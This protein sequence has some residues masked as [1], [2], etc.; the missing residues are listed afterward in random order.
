MQAQYL[1]ADY[2]DPEALDAALE[3]VDVMINLLGGKSLSFFHFS[4]L[5]LFL[6][7]AAILIILP[8]SLTFWSFT[9]PR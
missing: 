6:L 4:S 3:N 8:T 2:D 5:P 1:Y 7:P 9:L